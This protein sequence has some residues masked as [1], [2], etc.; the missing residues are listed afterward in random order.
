[1]TAAVGITAYGAYVPMRRFERSA[2]HECTGWFAPGLPID[3]ERAWCGW[4]EDV[5]TMSLEAARDCLSG[6]GDAP[7]LTTVTLASTTSPFSDRLGAAVLCG[8]LSLAGDAVTADI[9]G[10]QRAGTSAL[11]QALLASRPDEQSLC[12][13]AE[14]IRSRS[15]S[16]E[17]ALCGDGAAAFATGTDTIVAECLGWHSLTADFVDH[18]RAREQTFNYAWESRWV[19]DEGIATL[20]PET[21]RQALVRASIDPGMVDRFIFPSLIRGAAKAVA[22]QVGIRPDA[23]SDSLE[24]VVGNCGAAAPLLELSLALETAEPGEVIVVAAFGSGADAIVFRRTTSAGAGPRTGIS[25]WLRRRRLNNNY[26]KFLAARGLIELEGG[27]R[28]EFDQKQSMSALWRN[29][30]ALSGLQGAKD[31]TSGRVIFPPPPGPLDDET[32]FYVLADDVAR[33]VTFTADRL[34]YSLDPPTCYGVIDFPVGSRMSAEFC[35]VQ[36]ED[37]EVEMNV[38][39]MFRIKALDKQRDFRS[40]FWK[41]TPDYVGASKKV[42]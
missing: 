4:D 27:I 41:A 9:G 36:P 12:V 6:L 8:A 28:A 21:V 37:L 34:A 32:E 11:L 39:M 26:L 40:Y 10:S 1:M 42:S 14:Q 16:I 7:K 3:G 24:A 31:P 35:D 5:L 33:I 22:R 23:V 13:C 19:R 25:G 30:R 17:E 29:R 38:R 2:M 18:F 20:V 15:A